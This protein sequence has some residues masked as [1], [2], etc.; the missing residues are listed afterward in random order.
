MLEAAALRS[1]LQPCARGCGL[2]AALRVRMREYAPLV[3]QSE[4]ERQARDGG[5][6]WYARACVCTRVRTM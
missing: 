2:A 1:R 3:E 5:L 6:G 4:V